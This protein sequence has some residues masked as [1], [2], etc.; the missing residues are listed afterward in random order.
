MEQG[1]GRTMSRAL[2][3]RLVKLESALTP[4]P[5]PYVIPLI[6]WN[7]PDLEQIL[8]E[9]DRPDLLYPSVIVLVGATK[10][11]CR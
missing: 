11:D 10:E 9:H 6:A 4:P 8:A 1:E 3:R 2:E 5:P 7:D